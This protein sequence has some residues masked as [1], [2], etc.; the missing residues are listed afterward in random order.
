MFSYSHR[1]SKILK[2]TWYLASEQAQHS[3]LFAPFSRVCGS[4]AVKLRPSSSMNQ[5]FSSS[6]T[7]A[8]KQYK[9]VDI[10]L[11]D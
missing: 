6:K 9:Q 11:Y 2:F 8:L 7:I 10:K 1:I 5:L 3:S 4:H